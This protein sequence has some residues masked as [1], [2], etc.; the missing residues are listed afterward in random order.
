MS[1]IL[2]DT[3]PP[4]QDVSKLGG[5][6]SQVYGVLWASALMDNRPD[7]QKHLPWEQRR[8]CGGTSEWTVTGL[9]D[10]LKACK[11]SIRRALCVLLDEGFIQV[12]GYGNSKT[13]TKHTIWRVTHP[14]YLEA[15]RSALCFM[16]TPS[17]KWKEQMEAK[18]YIYQG[19][20]WDIT[21]DPVDWPK[22]FDPN[23]FGLYGKDYA[24]KVTQR[25]A[26]FNATTPRFT[27]TICPDW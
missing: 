9:A 7:P 3:I 5:K 17:L 24:K 14:D 18:R 8:D 20:I 19:E 2:H 15:C 22:H 6:A 13:G 27:Q 11:K 25:V 10:H 12:Q 1:V 16:G 21:N 4:L 23:Y 26:F